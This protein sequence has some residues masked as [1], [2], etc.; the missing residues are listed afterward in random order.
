MKQDFSEVLK[1]IQ[2]SQQKAYKQVNTVLI[3]LYMEIGKYVSLKCVKENWGKSVVQ[4]LA[5]FIKLQ[6]PTI[7]GFTARSIWRM[8]Q[9]YETYNTN[10]KLSPL[11]TQ[12]SWSNHLL[13]LSAAKSDEERAFYITISIKE[14][15][16]KRELER[17]ISSGLYQRTMLG[18][19]KLSVMVRELP[20]DTKNVFKDSYALEF[21]GLP[22]EHSEKDLQQGLVSSLKDFIL[23]IGK[24]FC[25]MGQEYKVQVGDTDFSIDLLFYHRNLQCMVAFELKIDDFKPSYLGQLEFYLEALDRDVKKEYENP[26]IGVLLCRK[27]NE[28]IVEYALSRSLSPTVISEYE[29]QLIPKKILQDKLDELYL[30]FEGDDK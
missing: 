3:E 12:I 8:K 13:I 23:E 19:E 18:N 7:K 20:Q 11:V 2:L 29:T 1:Q 4:E 17:Q 26:S 28:E 14:R 5:D 10:E 22:K 24:D 25:F 15:Y 16:S 27:K 30:Q 21:L 6:D 9:F